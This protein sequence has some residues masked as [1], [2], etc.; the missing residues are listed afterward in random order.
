M[1]YKMKRYQWSIAIGLLI[2]IVWLLIIAW[3]QQPAP[4]IHTTVPAAAPAVQQAVPQVP[5]ADYSPA[6][7]G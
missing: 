4:E 3:S 7:K 5:A 2:G 1:T 6:A